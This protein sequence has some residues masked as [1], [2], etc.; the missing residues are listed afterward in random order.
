MSERLPGEA[1][2]SC[3]ATLAVLAPTVRS[4]A[5][6]WLAM[7]EAVLR[8]VAF[9][10]QQAGPG[11][12]DVLARLGPFATGSEPYTWDELQELAR[13]GETLLQQARERR[14]TQGSDPLYDVLHSTV[15][16]HLAG[17]AAAGV[18][19]LRERIQQVIRELSEQ[20]QYGQTSAEVRSAL[21]ACQDVSLGTM[22]GLAGALESAHALVGSAPRTVVGRGELVH[23]NRFK[24][25][26][27]EDEETW[28]EFA[29]AAVAA[30]RNELGGG[31]EVEE[32]WFDNAADAREALCAQMSPKPWERQG[33]V[34][35]VQTIAIV[36]MGLPADREHLRAIEEYRS[37]PSRDNGHNLLRDLRSYR[38]NIPCIVFT[39]GP[40][41]LADQLRACAQG[42]DDVDYILKST[43]K[44]QAL[45]GA[46][47]GLC[48]QAQAHRIELRKEPDYAALVDGVPVEFPD[49]AFHAFYALC[50]LSRDSHRTRAHYDATQ[51]RDE[52]A[53][54]FD[55]RY[56][57]LREP[58]NRWEQAQALARQRGRGCWPANTDIVA[59][60]VIQFWATATDQAQ[61]EGESLEQ[62]LARFYEMHYKVARSAVELLHAYVRHHHGRAPWG[63]RAELPVDR[64]EQA[65]WFEAV[66]G[67]LG[68]TAWDD[69][70][71][72][73]LEQHVYTM[74]QAVHVAFQQVHRHGFPSQIVHGGD[75][76]RGFGYRV[77]GIIDLDDATI[78]VPTRVPNAVAG[79]AL[80]VLLIENEPTWLD[81]I[82]G[83]LTDFGFAV[84]PATHVEEA[85]QLAAV[86]RPD[87]LCLDM[88]LPMTRREWE[89]NPTGG[90]RW[91]G[92]R[93]LAQIRQFLPQVAVMCPT[94]L[95]NQD[96]LRERAA[97]LGVPVT[98]F[99]PKGGTVDGVPWE[100]LL[101]LTANRLRQ[102]LRLGVCLPAV[103]A[104][105]SPIVRLL[106]GCDLVDGRLKL[107]VNGR[108]TGFR[109]SA[110]GRLVALLLQSAEE[111]VPFDEVDRYVAGGPVDENTR[112]QWLKNVRSKI[113]SDWLCVPEG[114]DS[115]PELE[116]L[117][118]V[119][120]GLVLHAMVEGL[121]AA[122][123]G[124]GGANGR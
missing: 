84:V 57:G 33:T 27:I 66:F 47:L 31:Y 116:V 72:T 9:A 69:Y 2:A 49:A 102:E 1:L 95:H 10:E 19:D 71:A 34:R 4:R 86:E 79:A 53:A 97:A 89:A 56:Q 42:V 20:P 38:T 121:A 30:V 101:L 5:R 77:D 44:L 94:T 87:I 28:R 32:A 45:T 70:T 39:V 90:D 61:R 68:A 55:D 93:A 63:S 106:D 22:E 91:G 54:I 23:T 6:H 119:E 35:P 26:V 88:H 40:Q 52:I 78:G 51:V 83:L 81:S 104:W 80:S 36:D 110:Q 75:A 85:V 124:G 113:R 100:A 7:R 11:A 115:R 62:G 16:Q 123:P 109:A 41:L 64:T 82:Q 43:N 13:A 67:G 107:E 73:D 50:R 98:N 15:E 58:L 18:D 29:L 24:I 103:P 96:E 48:A 114:D 65:Q 117:Q 17:D 14:A 108:S 59:A 21:E 92:L 118:T 120:G 60:N 25:V 112:K 74:R 46:L 122:A 3:R 99:V 111:T 37:A 76:E 12:A 105:R 8:A